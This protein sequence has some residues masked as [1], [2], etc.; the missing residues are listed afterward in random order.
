[1]DHSDSIDVAATPEAVFE[2][3]S[4]LPGMGRFS[5]ENTGGDWLGGVS[6]PALGAR[7]RGTNANGS[8]TWTTA[9]RVTAFD[10]PSRFSFAVTFLGLKIATWS[11]EIAATPTGSRVTESWLD[12]RSTFVK[13]FASTVENREDFTRESVRHT[14][15]ALKAELER[16]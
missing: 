11:Y 7:F 4:D 9:A 5:P 1:V 16:S 10:P 14:L 2:L 3:V 12:Q 8:K 15:V 13:R 6:A